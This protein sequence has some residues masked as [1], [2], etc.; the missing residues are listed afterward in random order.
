MSLYVQTNQPIL[1]PDADYTVGAADS[2]KIFIFTTVTGLR[3]ITL[4]AVSAGLH[5]IFINKAPGALGAAGQNVR[6]TGGA[7]SMQGIL[8]VGAAAG[9]VANAYVNF[10]GVTSMKGDRLDVICD[11]IQWSVVATASLNG[12]FTAAE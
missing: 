6:I 12:A 3:T 8:L 7:L 4:P 2:G 5:Y 11:G 10:I 9:P 1:L